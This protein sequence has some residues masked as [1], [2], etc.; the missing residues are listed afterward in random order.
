MFRQGLLGK[1]NRMK[2]HIICDHIFPAKND[3]TGKMAYLLGE[4]FSEFCEVHFYTKCFFRFKTT[5]KMCY[6][7]FQTY[8]SL[9]AYEFSSEL[10]NRPFKHWFR[11]VPFFINWLMIKSKK[12]R[13][14]D[15]SRFLFFL[16]KELQVEKD[17]LIILIVGNYKLIDFS[18]FEFPGKK[19]LIATDSWL[20]GNNLIND[21][22]LDLI[23]LFDSVFAFWP[24]VYKSSFFKNINEFS[25][26]LKNSEFVRSCINPESKQMYYFGTIG[27]TRNIYKFIDFIEK[28]NLDYE[29]FFYVSDKKIRSNNSKIHFLDPVYGKKYYETIKKSDILFLLDNNEIYSHF[30]QS[31]IYEYV[32]HGKPI[33]LFTE[34]S[35]SFN[36]LELSKY[37]SF[38]CINY[39]DRYS[40]EKIARFINSV[41]VKRKEGSLYDYYPGCDVERFVEQILNEKKEKKYEV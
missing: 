8:D 17:D 22:L 18:L 30:L 12:K 41:N 10:K 24:T 28:Q 34:N 9:T 31:K 40:N 4:Q 23:P 19:I 26:L 5:G 2:V 32:S 35:N 29:F 11:T 33:I 36:E 21:Y 15:T 38:L 39:N 20:I 1:E 13:F 3:P 25:Y 27:K 16:K 7:T 6:H 37:D 14:N